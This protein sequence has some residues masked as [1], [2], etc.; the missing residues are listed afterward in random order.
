MAEPP[1]STCNQT[2]LA[3]VSSMAEPNST[4]NQTTLYE[5]S[6]LLLVAV[7]SIVFTVGVP[8]NF[9]TAVLTSVQI[10]R[11]N[12]LSIYLF[13]L[14]LCE[15]MYLSTLPHWIIYVQNGHCWTMGETA[16]K[17]IGYIFFCNIY[18]SILLLCCISIDRYVAVVYPLR[19]R[20][21]RNQRIATGV[22][23]TLF[24]IVAAIYSPVFF[25]PNIQ[26]PNTT[27]CFE[28]SLNNQLA[29]FNIIRF[30]VGFAIPF[31]ILIVTNYKIFQNIKISCSLSP[32]KKSKVKYLAIA[33]ISIFVVCFAPYH[34]DLLAR[35]VCFHLHWHLKVE[36]KISTIFLCLST[37]NS[38][39]DPFIYVLA[40]EN[41]RNEICRTFRSAGVRFL[42]ESKTES[43][44]P[45]STQKTPADPSEAHK[46]ER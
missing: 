41:A 3:C 19:S 39:A 26:A 25:D 40:S 23:S 32:Q 12:I 9:M 6:R 24:A 7:Y 22:T 14:S 4:C 29:T 43:N 46:E 15:L 38:V 33:I 2:S 10:H 17:V 1:N 18:I 21:L 37:A 20:G 16:C 5:E 28:S 35:A 8:A 42:N 30:L 34:F 31:T 44:K 36:N 27:T 11:G 13:G 45:N